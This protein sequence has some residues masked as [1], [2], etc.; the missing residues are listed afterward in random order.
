[1]LVVKQFLG[2]RHFMTNVRVTSTRI[3]HYLGQ[4]LQTM[5]NLS[6]IPLQVTNIIHKQEGEN[7]CEIKIFFATVHYK[8]NNNNKY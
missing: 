1:M 7:K 8:N 4:N 6:V 3:Q 5:L 2:I